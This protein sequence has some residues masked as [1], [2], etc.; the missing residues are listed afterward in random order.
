MDEVNK[1]FPWDMA[2]KGFD[3]G[4]TCRECME[5]Y[6]RPCC[7]DS[8]IE[9]GSECGNLDG[10]RCDFEKWETAEPTNK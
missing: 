1:Y 10:L 5:N 4:E 7:D 2:K 8:D 6:G 3:I 9:D